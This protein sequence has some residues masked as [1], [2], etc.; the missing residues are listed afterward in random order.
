[1][2]V[3]FKKISALN[4]LETAD[5]KFLTGVEDTLLAAA[6]TLGGDI[7]TDNGTQ[8]LVNKTLDAANNTLSNIDTTM[9]SAGT[10]DTDSTLAANSD[11]VLATQKAVK[12]YV[13][14]ASGAVSGALVFKGAFDASTGSFPANANKGYYYKVTVAG[15]IDG[16]EF[17]IGD[18]LFAEIDTAATDTYTGNWFLIDNTEAAIVWA[19]ITD[20][21]ASLEQINFLSNVTSDVQTQLNSK[22]NLTQIDTDNTLAADSDTVI[23]SQK[24]IKSYVDTAIENF[25]AIGSTKTSAA[26]VVTAGAAT[27]SEPALLISGIYVENEGTIFS[28]FTHTAET[29]Q[30]TFDD[31]TLDGKNIF[32]TYTI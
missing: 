19:N 3:N 20:A 24:A 12:A 1:M 26:L 2:A 11:T 16:A 27:L 8:T 29:D 14:A 31:G 25:Q 10:I 21:T 6:V 7:V 15:T 28:G 22:V 23:P 4:V 30:I 17:N 18:T 9:F 13:D 5:R 32:V